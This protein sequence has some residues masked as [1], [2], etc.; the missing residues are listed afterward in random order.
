MS[1]DTVERL[2]ALGDP[3]RAE[4]AVLVARAQPANRMA[5]FEHL[6]GEI[7]E[8]DIERAAARTS[9]RRPRRD[10]NA[11]PQRWDRPVLADGFVGTTSDPRTVEEAAR[12]GA[13][14]LT[15]VLSPDRAVALL[16]SMARRHETRDEA[17]AELLRIETDHPGTVPVDVVAELLEDGL[18]SAR[19]EPYRLAVR[20]GSGGATLNELLLERCTSSSHPL[21]AAEALRA[22][23]GDDAALRQALLAGR[24]DFKRV[25]GS[26]RIDREEDE[27]IAELANSIEWTPTEREQILRGFFRGTCGLQLIAALG[28]DAAPVV[29]ELCRRLQRHYLASYH[30]EF[31]VSSMPGAPFARTLAAIGPAAGDAAPAVRHWV[32]ATGGGD[33]DGAAILIAI[34]SGED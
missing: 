34:G 11:G 1:V 16:S 10:R 22:V 24:S 13:V 27:R 14:A 15:G 28:D 3:G 4:I 7:T 29:P 19:R 2:K 23:T 17:L 18:A 8:E 32:G 30:G 20:L 6:A 9:E 31:R 26:L 33:D 25:I 12:K 5:L 21:A